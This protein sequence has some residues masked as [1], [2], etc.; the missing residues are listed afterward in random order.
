MKFSF[1]DPSGVVCEVTLSKPSIANAKGCHDQLTPAQ[2]G[3]M[4][5]AILAVLL[6]IFGPQPPVSEPTKSK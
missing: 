6:S 5:Q 4:I 2:W 3:A 1:T